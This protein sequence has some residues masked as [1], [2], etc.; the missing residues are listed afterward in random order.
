MA[1]RR[2]SANVSFIGSKTSGTIERWRWRT[3]M[4]F[5]FV[6][7][8]FAAFRSKSFYLHTPPTY[9]MTG[10]RRDVR[11]TPTSRLSISSIMGRWCWRATMFLPFAFSTKV[12]DDS[13]KARCRRSTN[14]S[15]IESGLSGTMERWWW[16]TTMIFPFAVFPSAFITNIPTDSSKA[17]HRRSTNVSLI[18][19]RASGTIERW[20]CGATVIF[21]LCPQSSPAAPVGLTFTDTHSCISV[22]RH[23]E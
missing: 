8:P 3:K 11:E 12:P 21:L 16:K 20:W 6:D 4:V 1:R 5:P 22:S 15:L 13:S 10:Q 19:S 17:R 14:V 2:R 18:G 9:R 23:G 7:F